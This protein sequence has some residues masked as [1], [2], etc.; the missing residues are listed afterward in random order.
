M[1]WTLTGGGDHAGVAWTPS[2]G[3]I[4]A[5]THTGVGVFTVASG[6]TVY[7][8][9]GVIIRCRTA[10][11]TGVLSASGRGYGGGSG[12]R[13]GYGGG[14]GVDAAQGLGVA[15]SAGSGTYGGAGGAAGWNG[16]LSSTA[17]YGG[18]GAAGGRGGYLGSGKNGDTTTNYNVYRGSG[19]GGSGGGG[20][21]CRYIACGIGNENYAGGSGGGGGAGAFGGGYVR[22]EATEFI[23][24]DG[25]INTT[26]S[27]SAGNGTAG[28]TASCRYNIRSYGA[29]GSNTASGSRAGGTYGYGCYPGQTSGDGTKTGNRG[30][31]GGTG[32]VGA[33]GGIC[34]ACSGAFGIRV[35]GTIDTRGGGNNTTNYGSLKL[36]GRY[37]CTGWTGYM[38]HAG[39][40]GYGTAY[41]G[42]NMHRFGC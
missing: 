13:G 26:G 8:T 38:G 29:G 31:P 30:G 21:G 6:R 15:G 39:S 19:G 32:G 36:F 24:V 41:R 27:S 17:A 3:Q 25:Q 9:T 37:N 28:G 40:G 16:Q 10:I 14:S 34:L 1:A 12:G 4:I 33:G 11:I 18:T 35:S 20:G 5:G 23:F 2:S 7:V 42:P 22:I